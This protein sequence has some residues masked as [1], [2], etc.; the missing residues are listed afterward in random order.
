MNYDGNRINLL[1]S[2]LRTAT[3]ITEIKRFL[4]ADYSG[5]A[6]L[7]LEVTA[8]EA[9]AQITD[10]KVYLPSPQRT[11]GVKTQIYGFT[12]GITAT[13]IYTFLI[14]P[15]GAAGGLFT[16]AVEGYFPSEYLIEV[17]PLDTKEITYSLWVLPWG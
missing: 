15:G 14:A 11:A 9:L 10:V 8:I 5:A 7:V 6:L 3:A 4:S 12:P 13:G 2:L 1:A 17:V 16:G